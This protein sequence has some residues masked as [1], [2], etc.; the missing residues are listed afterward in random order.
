MGADII[1]CSV[2]WSLVIILKPDGALTATKIAL[3]LT[4][5]ISRIN[6]M[7]SKKIKEIK[8]KEIKIK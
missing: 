7:L 5:Y 2:P 6:P 3:V 4:R 1:F 8:I